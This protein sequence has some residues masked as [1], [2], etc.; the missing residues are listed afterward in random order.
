MFYTKTIIG[1]NT[2][3]CTTYMEQAAGALSVAA[4]MRWSIAGSRGQSRF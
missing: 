1:E 3:I 4:N 2:T